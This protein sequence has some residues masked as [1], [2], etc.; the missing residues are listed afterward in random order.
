MAEKLSKV[1]EKPEY[2]R[3]LGKFEGMKPEPVVVPLEGGAMALSVADVKEIDKDI[4]ALPPQARGPIIVT[5][6]DMGAGNPVF[7]RS[8]NIEY[9]FYQCVTPGCN[10]G[11]NGKPYR[12]FAGSGDT[13]EQR[14]CD[15]IAQPAKLKTYQNPR[16]SAPQYEHGVMKLHL[17]R[18]PRPK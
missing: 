6:D 3:P 16:I 13:D 14:E 7:D 18:M 8:E 17:F 15:C 9:R 12:T 2:A 4:P 10:M 1:T 11:K 5:D